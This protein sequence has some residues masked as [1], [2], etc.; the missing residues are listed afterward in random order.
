MSAFTPH[1]EDIMDEVYFVTSYEALAANSQVAEPHLAEGVAS[2]LQKGY[3]NQLEFD[4]QLGDYTKRAEA[5]LDNVSVYHYVA[6]KA[7]LLA[8]N[9]RM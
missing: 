7:G 9:S 8:H 5:D 4:Q 2:L 3:V 1:E 6:S